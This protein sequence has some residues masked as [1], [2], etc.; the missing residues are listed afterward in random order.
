MVHTMLQSDPDVMDELMKA[1]PISRL[2]RPEEV[3][4]AV[5]WLC[6]P[7]AS[8]CEFAGDVV[9]TGEGADHWHAGDRVTGGRNGAFAEYVVADARH[10]LPTPAQLTDVE[11]ATLPTALHTEYG[12]LTVAGFTAGQSVLL[13]GGTSAIGLV[14]PQ[15]AKALGASLVLTTTRDPAKEQRLLDLGATAVL[16]ASDNLAQSIRQTTGGDGVDVVLDHIG[17]ATFTAA[18]NAT[19]TAGSIVNIGRLDCATTQVDLDT[20]SAHR[21]HVHGVSYSY[22]RPDDMA[23]VTAAVRNDIL[24]ALADG[25]IQ[26]VVDA[27]FTLDE[28]HAAAARVRSGDTF[29][30]IVLTL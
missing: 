30:K 11:A 20:V 18:I 13:T 15:I 26:P 6:S 9:Q 23:A 29:G 16:V 28:A 5:L 24:P 10:L 1:Q 22:G 4:S 8:G 27:T 17:G 21:L 14:G 3:A 2:G 7:G 25:R 12:A 19:A